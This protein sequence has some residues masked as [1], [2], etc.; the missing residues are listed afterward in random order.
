MKTAVSIPDG[1]FRAAEQASERLGIPR[2]ELYQRALADYL[3]RH[4][5]SLVTDALNQV[6]R[7]EQ[8]IPLDPVLDRMQLASL[9]RETW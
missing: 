1:L 7:A 2:S 4:G 3:D 8:P 9:P 5:A 6:Y